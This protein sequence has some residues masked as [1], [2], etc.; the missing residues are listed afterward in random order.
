[1]TSFSLIAHYTRILS[2]VKTSCPRKRAK[3]VRKVLRVCVAPMRGVF[4]VA[5]V[6]VVPFQARYVP[7]LGRETLKDCSWEVEELNNR[8]CKAVNGTWVAA[9]IFV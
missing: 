3:S 5:W 4:L 9:I 6:L 2:E 7:I 1:M 8:R